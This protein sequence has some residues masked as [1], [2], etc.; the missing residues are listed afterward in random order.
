MSLRSERYR[1]PELPLVPLIDVLV[2]LVFFTFA[3]M[4][5]REARGGTLNLTLP[6]VETAGKNVFHSQVVIA[7]DKD[8]R[9]RVTIT[10]NNGELVLDKR[11]AT[12]DEIENLAGELA[13]VDKSITVL[14]RSDEN[15]PLKSVTKV[16][17]LCRKNG[18]NT[19]RL[20]TR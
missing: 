9:V 4:Q 16:M 18:L 13:K 2:M 20:Q 14:I 19:I 15:A 1:R 12:V 3:T 11:E 17:D 5:F 8:D 7:V 10:G 6:K